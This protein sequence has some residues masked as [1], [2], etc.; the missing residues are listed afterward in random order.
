MKKKILVLSLVAALVAIAAVGG[1][2][3]WFMDDD[4]ATNVFTVGSIEI[5]QIEVFDETT[6]QLLPIVPNDTATRSDDANFIEKDVSVKNVG[7]NAAFVQTFVAVPAALDNND[8]IVIN[9]V[10]TDK[11]TKVQDNATEYFATTTIEGKAYNVYLYRYNTALAAGTA[12]QESVTELLM[13]GVYIPSNVDMDVT[14]DV[15]D[16]QVGYFKDAN[17]VYI[18]E[19][20]ALG[21]LNIYVATQAV[22]VEGFASAEAA[23]NSAFTAIPDFEA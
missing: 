18:S 16:N 3:A 23:L 12:Q 14:T 15:N 21:E 1:T 10:N 13:D 20:N 19:F 8:I 9:E 6:A 22:Q 2:L 7:R 17:G 5:E 11:W 4:S